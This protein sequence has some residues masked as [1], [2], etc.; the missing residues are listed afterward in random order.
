MTLRKLN[1]VDLANLA[2]EPNFSIRQS[3]L[4]KRAK[5]KPYGW[6]YQLMRKA[7]QPMYGASSFPAMPLPRLRG[8]ELDKYIQE[9]SWNPDQLKACREIA[10][11]LTR[12]VD[13]LDGA[14]CTVFDPIYLGWHGSV[15]FWSD[16]IYRANGKSHICFT[17]Y[18]R[19]G[20]LTEGGRLVVFSAM[21]HSIR[22]TNFDLIDAELVILQYKKVDGERRLNIHKASELKQPLMTAD[23]L[24]HRLATTIEQWKVALTG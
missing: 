1:S 9:K 24:T 14:F 16:L 5:S 15:K 21:H 10:T 11:L 2:A 6:N 13:G 23:E 12:H 22:M 17:D 7:E 4:V 8:V 20:G 19:G 18:R 3:K